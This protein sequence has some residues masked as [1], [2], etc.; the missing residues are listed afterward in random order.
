[1]K[2]LLLCL[3]AMLLTTAAIAQESACHGPLTGPAP[4]P[5]SPLK[6][7]YGHAFATEYSDAATEFRELCQYVN[8]INIRW[9]WRDVNPSAGVYDFSEID[10]A[11][12]ALQAGSNP[13]CAFFFFPEFKLFTGGPVTNGQERNPGPAD[14]ADSTCVVGAG[15]PAGQGNYPSVD[16][17]AKVE[18]TNATNATPIVITSNGHPFQNGD[19]V[20]IRNVEGNGAANITGGIVAGRTAN[21]FQLTDSTG[22]NVAGSGAYTTG[23]SAFRQS[24]FASKMYDPVVWA[25]F[26]AM[27]DAF[28]AHTF[29]G[30]TMDEHPNIM[31]VIFQETALG[32]QQA[33]NRAGAPGNFM[34]PDYAATIGGL[35][36]AQRFRDG[37]IAMY[38][39]CALEAAQNRC[40]SF[41]NFLTNGQAFIKSAIM[42]AMDPTEH[43]PGALRTALENNK[44]VPGGPDVLPDSQSLW[45]SNNSIYQ[46]IIDWD[47]GRADHSGA[48]SN[49]AQNNSFK[50]AGFDLEH[51]WNFAVSGLW[52]EF[53]QPADRNGSTVDPTDP[54]N[55]SPR[56]AGLCVNTWLWWNHL[57]QV[58]PATGQAYW[59][60]VIPIIAAHPY[61]ADWYG[62]CVG[63]GGVP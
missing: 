37:L 8:V 36:G 41:V 62:R 59:R 54:L 28:Q 6:T 27:I 12:L 23:G 5:E 47:A 43:L 10:N 63:G 29:Q 20:T 33:T 55:R 32:L 14:L 58:N 13:N 44:W 48:R 38:Q 46:A 2:K 11:I 53:P 19:T 51:V 56:T 60:G 9:R 25:R 50:I 35:T 42:P 4:E 26:N 18:I 49:S 24:I 57:T 45:F 31:G 61:G 40:L 34:P 3:A 22:T 39:N 30:F 1:M 7:R 21:T 52:G 17:V 16:T 15:C